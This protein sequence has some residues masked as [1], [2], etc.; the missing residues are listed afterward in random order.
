LD[1]KH[2]RYDDFFEWDIT[3]NDKNILKHGVNFQ[4]A[5]TVF[6]DTRAVVLDDAAH[7]HDEERFIIIGISENQRL[8]MVCHCY[9]DNDELIRIISARK[10]EKVEEAIYGGA[11]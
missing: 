2:F 1:D 10:A 3:K 5:S 6:R 4:E 11:R 7:S 9:R 8:L